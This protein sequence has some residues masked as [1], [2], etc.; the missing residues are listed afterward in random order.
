M[1]N[2]YCVTEHLKGNLGSKI[3]SDTGK[4]KHTYVVEVINLVYYSIFVFCVAFQYKFLCEI[5]LHM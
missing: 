3:A 4:M 1:R 2:I 5:S